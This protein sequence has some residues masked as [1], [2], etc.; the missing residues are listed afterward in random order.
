MKSN[1]IQ[2][3]LNFLRKSFGKGFKIFL[4]TILVENREKS[5]SW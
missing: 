2:N 1:V 4:I 3:F 5:H